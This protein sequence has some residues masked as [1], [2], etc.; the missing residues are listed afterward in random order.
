MFWLAHCLATFEGWL[1]VIMVN[2]WIILA[3]SL[4]R[5]ALLAAICC[6]DALKIAVFASLD[7]FDCVRTDTNRL[8]M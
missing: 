5:C 4:L 7:A 8:A 6:I 3:C 1:V 2:C